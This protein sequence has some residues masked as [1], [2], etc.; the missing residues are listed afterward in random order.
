MVE[1]MIAPSHVICSAYFEKA[2][3]DIICD[4]PGGL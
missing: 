2:T 3:V 4:G 1:Q